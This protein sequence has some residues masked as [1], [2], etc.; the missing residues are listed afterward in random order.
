MSYIDEKLEE[1]RK[2]GVERMKEQ[3]RL[4][5]LDQWEEDLV[6]ARDCII[7]LR[8]LV[9]K[10]RDQEHVSSHDYGIPM[11]KSA[12]VLKH[13]EGQLNPEEAKDA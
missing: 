2:R 1:F 5:T 13:I 11:V 6:M 8:K 10:Y 7:G 3:N 9:L 12:E 4:E